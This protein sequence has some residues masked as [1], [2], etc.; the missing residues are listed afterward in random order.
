MKQISNRALIFLGSIPH[1]T[2]NLF[3]GKRV[4]LNFYFKQFNRENNIARFY[5]KI[6]VDYL[7]M[8]GI[9]NYPK[10]FNDNN[11]KSS[12]E[13]KDK[14]IFIN[15]SSNN[16]NDHFVIPQLPKLMENKEASC[17][18]R[19]SK[20]NSNLKIISNQKIVSDNLMKLILNYLDSKSIPKQELTNSYFHR[21]SQ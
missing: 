5:D 6:Y 14:L 4:N 18:I 12:E 17:L 8:M 10:S 19:D 13:D 2:R 20:D 9:K 15:G 7:A 3:E 16:N 11:D 1:E 21:L